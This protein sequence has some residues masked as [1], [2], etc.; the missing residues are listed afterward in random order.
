MEEGDAVFIDMAGHT[1]IEARRN[2]RLFPREG[3]ERNEGS[4]R[5]QELLCMELEMYYSQNVAE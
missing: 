2:M 5:V 3:L 4:E 1:T